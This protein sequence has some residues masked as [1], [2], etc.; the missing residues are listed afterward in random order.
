MPTG[1]RTGWWRQRQVSSP[2]H[3]VTDVVFQMNCSAFDL[4]VVVSQVC[5]CRTGWWRQHQVRRAVHGVTDVVFQMNCSAFNLVVVVGQ[6]CRRRTGW[7][8]QRQ[9]SS[10]AQCAVKSGVAG[11][12]QCTFWLLWA[13]LRAQDRVVAPALGEQC[14]A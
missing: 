6:V 9:V 14:G 12:L 1:R 11:D 2:A 10:A 13:D 4:V 8:R 3:N 5:R 7:W